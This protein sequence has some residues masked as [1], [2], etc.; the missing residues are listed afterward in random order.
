DFSILGILVILIHIHFLHNHWLLM[1]YFCY[2]LRVILFGRHYDDEYVT[3]CKLVDVICQY[4]HRL[5]ML[6]RFPNYRLEYS[7]AV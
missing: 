7:Y 3:Y 5:T 1:F 4:F 6:Y 2:K